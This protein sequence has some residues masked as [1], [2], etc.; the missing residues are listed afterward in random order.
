MLAVSCFLLQSPDGDPATGHMAGEGSLPSRSRAQGA[1][2]AAIASVFVFAHLISRLGVTSACRVSSKEAWGRLLPLAC[3]TLTSKLHP[4]GSIRES[5]VLLPWSARLRQQLL[6]P[7]AVSIISLNAP[8]IW[9]SSI[10]VT[11]ATE[12]HAKRVA[13]PCNTMHA[14]VLLTACRQGLH[15]LSLT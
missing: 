10:E 6:D 12:A 5:S 2:N 15:P 14:C 1:G 13:V 8:A 4:G 3:N 9:S 7:V 11:E